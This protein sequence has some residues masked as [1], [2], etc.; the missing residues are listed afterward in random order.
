MGS[1]SNIHPKV[2]AGT[3]VG[4]VV[5]LVWF[6]LYQCG[7]NVDFPEYVW[8]ALGTLVTSVSAWFKRA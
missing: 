8:V 6:V 4:A 7:I 2:K 3:T 5:T 1:A